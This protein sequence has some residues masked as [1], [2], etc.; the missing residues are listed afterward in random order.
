MHTNQCSSA[1]AGGSRMSEESEYMLSLLQE[2][3]VLKNA[4]G[5]GID[6]DVASRRKRLKE[7]KK[8]MKDLAA[9]KNEKE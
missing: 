8:E 3:A 5:P 2:L 7:I 1:Y 6:L 4:E 9:S